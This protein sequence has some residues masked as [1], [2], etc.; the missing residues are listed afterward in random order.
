MNDLDKKL[1]LQLE[2]ANAAYS[3]ARN[4]LTLLRAQMCEASDQLRAAEQIRAMAERELSAIERAASA[5][6]D[7]SDPVMH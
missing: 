6:R 7:L 1:R 3:A 4:K 5:R 2:I